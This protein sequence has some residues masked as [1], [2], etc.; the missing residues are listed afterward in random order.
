MAL[1]TEKTCTQCGKT[2][3]FYQG[4]NSLTPSIC[5][6]CKEENEAKEKKEFLEK[7]KQE[8]IEKRIAAIEEWMYDHAHNEKMH[9]YPLPQWIG[10]AH[11][12]D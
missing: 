6:E 2:R 12:T 7:M 3:I 10:Y 11:R 8:A 5:S 9:D 1:Q 4:I